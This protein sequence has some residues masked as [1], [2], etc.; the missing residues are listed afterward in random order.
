MGLSLVAVFLCVHRTFRF[1]APPTTAANTESMFR[2]RASSAS[3]EPNGGGGATGGMGRAER[4]PRE[5]Q[6]HQQVEACGPRRH[7]QFTAEAR[8]GQG[9]EG[10]PRAG[11]DVGRPGRRVRDRSKLADRLG[12]RAARRRPHLHHRVQRVPIWK[13][14]SAGHRAA[15][16][17]GQAE[18]HARRGEGRR[19]WRRRLWCQR[20]LLRLHGRR[21]RCRLAW[22]SACRFLPAL[23]DSCEPA[24]RRSTNRGA[25]ARAAVPSLRPAKGGGR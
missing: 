21:V 18:L 12:Q 11:R 19:R 13:H 1:I 20:R 2:R 25:V 4:R 6:A 9:R 24:G 16:V 23:A 10:L 14:P 15:R 7:E 22:C 17:Q 5:G 3:N 8:A